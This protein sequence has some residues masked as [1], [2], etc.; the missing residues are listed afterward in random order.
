ML[1]YYYNLVN[2]VCLYA[3]GHIL[4]AIPLLLFIKVWSIIVIKST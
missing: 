3:M 1:Q 2:I 4:G